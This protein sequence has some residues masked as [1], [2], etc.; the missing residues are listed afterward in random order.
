MTDQCRTDS[1]TECSLLHLHG[2]HGRYDTNTTRRNPAELLA[3]SILSMCNAG[4]LDDVDGYRR[5]ELCVCV[6][7]LSVA[8]TRERERE[9]ER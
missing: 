1:I 3:W 8:N 7:S 4:P 2:I 5:G 6:G 9:R